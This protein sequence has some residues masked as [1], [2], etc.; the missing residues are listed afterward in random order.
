MIANLFGIAALSSVFMTVSIMLLTEQSQFLLCFP[1]P[2]FFE[3]EPPG[4]GMGNL[5]EKWVT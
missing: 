2:A 3:Q 1:K 4:T 5:F